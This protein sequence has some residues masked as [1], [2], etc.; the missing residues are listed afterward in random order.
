MPV[1]APISSGD[2]K[3][4]RKAFIILRRFIFIVAYTFLCAVAVFFL[5]RGVGAITGLVFGDGVIVSALSQLTNARVSVPV[6]IPLCGAVAVCAL[7]ALLARRP[8]AMVTV[9]SVVIL[10]LAFA[11]AFLL[12]KVNGV[13]VHVAIGI[14][15]MLLGSGMF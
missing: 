14:I 12:T 10:L 8:S 3:G 2:Q 13:F 15:K 9:L 7:R 1:P 4:G 5:I 11:A 6:W